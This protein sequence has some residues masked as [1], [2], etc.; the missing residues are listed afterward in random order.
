MRY[1]AMQVRRTLVATVF[2]TMV[3]AV[4]VCVVVDVGTP[5][6]LQAL[7]STA[8][9]SVANFRGRP[10]ILV[11]DDSLEVVVEDLEIVAEVPTVVVVLLEVVL[12]VVLCEDSGRALFEG[13][14]AMHVVIMVVLGLM[15]ETRLSSFCCGYLRRCGYGDR[16]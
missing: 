13:F 15:S 12:P 11:V 8:L 9:A 6:Q 4:D 14:P 5:R 7:E 16:T 2:V 3:E 1:V 10:A